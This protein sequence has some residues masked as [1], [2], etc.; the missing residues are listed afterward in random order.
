MTRKSIVLLFV[1]SLFLA[2]FEA[3]CGPLLPSP[4]KEVRPILDVIVIGMVLNSPGASLFISAVT[5]IF[6]PLFSLDN[7]FVLL[8][9]FIITGVLFVLGKSIL[10]NRSIYSAIAAMVS[11]RILD[12]L[13]AIVISFFGRTL[14]GWEEYSIPWSS[15]FITLCWDVGIIGVSFLC[16]ALFTKRFISSP[17]RTSSYDI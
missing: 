3:A 2:I 1:S 12:A 17:F 5:G 14:F 7:D 4:W 11:A 16:I 8:R 13:L 10:T 6:L 15:L 9:F